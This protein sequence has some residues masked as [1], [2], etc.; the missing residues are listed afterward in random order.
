[1]KDELGRQIMKKVVGLR[2]KS[3][4]YVKENYEEH[5]KAEGTK[6]KASWKEILSLETIKKSLKATKIENRIN[7]FENKKI[8]VDYLKEFVKNK[9][10]LKTQQR[11]KSERHNVFT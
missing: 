3:Y 6:K 4:S 9:V 5:K 10:I 1:M 7:Y 8:D 11:F 2:A